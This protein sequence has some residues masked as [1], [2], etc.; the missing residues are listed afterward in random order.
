MTAQRTDLRVNGTNL[1]FE[2][3]VAHAGNCEETPEI[4]W[5]VSGGPEPAAVITLTPICQCGA[6]EILSANPV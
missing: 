2:V 1:T 4:E 6:A 3:N 5:S